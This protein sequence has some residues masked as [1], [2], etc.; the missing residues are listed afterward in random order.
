VEKSLGSANMER[1]VTCDDDHNKTYYIFLND[2]EGTVLVN[3]YALGKDGLWCMYRSS[4]CRNVRHAMMHGG[5]MAFATDT[6]LFYF[7]A[8]ASKDAPEQIGGQTQTIC[9]LWE[10]GY[11]DFDVDYKRKY[12]SRIYVSMLPESSSSLTIT[13][14]TDRRESYREKVIGTNL[15]GW[16]KADFARWSFDMNDTPKIRRVQLKV[17]KFVYYKLIFK[18]EEP[19]TRATVLA[20]DQ[21]VRFSSMAK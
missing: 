2:D 3:R 9:A 17:K 10:S 11:M 7:D 12:S 13:A 15:F 4:L 1:I 6:E 19:G 5:T 8:D 16:S 21:Q 18:V 20:F 14:S